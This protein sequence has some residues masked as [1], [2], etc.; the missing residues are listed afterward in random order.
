MFQTVLLHSALK[1]CNASWIVTASL[2][3]FQENTQSGMLNSASI[4]LWGLWC[5]LGQV[6]T[7]A[8]PL[9][10]WS[11]NTSPLRAW[12]G[13]REWAWWCS[14]TTKRRVQLNKE[15]K[16]FKASQILCN[17]RGKSLFIQ[18]VLFH[19]L[20]GF[21]LFFNHQMTEEP[22]IWCC[23]LCVSLRSGL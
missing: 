20:S 14:K 12:M 7:A 19:Q 6:P 16:F 18:I 23:W 17:M 8:L 3:S 21:I 1:E 5:G 15:P 9:S 4:I 10:L 13:S 11:R 2:N 22:M